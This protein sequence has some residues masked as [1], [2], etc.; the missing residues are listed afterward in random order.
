MMLLILLNN[1][2]CD[3]T[4]VDVWLILSDYVRFQFSI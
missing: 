3:A 4:E 2:V 1:I